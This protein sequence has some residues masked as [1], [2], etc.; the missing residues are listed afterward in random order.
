MRSVLVI[1]DEKPTL[2]MFS[3]LL[4]AMGYGAL[5]ADSG[6]LGLE[7]FERERPRIVFTDIKMPDMD[8]LVVLARIKAMDPSAE[9]I[10]V[11]GHGDVELA[12]NSLNLDAAD[13]IDK[14]ISQP[15]LAGAL[16]RA[17]ERIN[18]REKA[19]PASVLREAEG[20]RVLDIAGNLSTGLDD[21]AQ[22]LAA[23]M[24]GGPLLVTVSECASINGAGIAGLTRIIQEQDARGGK[25]ALACKPQNFRRVFEAAGLTA[26]ASLHTAE[27]DG[28]REL[29]KLK[30]V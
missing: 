29:L 2:S 12:L 21:V 23:T 8:G 20:V 1:D 14:P 17:D 15:A 24:H 22:E 18:R 25:T 6:T 4:E 3:L 7:I 10:V 28:L 13:F 5:T 27:E 9:V 11:T 19:Q 26:L 16:S 30:S